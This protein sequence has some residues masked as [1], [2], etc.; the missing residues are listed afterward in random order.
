MRLSSKSAPP[1]ARLNPKGQRRVGGGALVAVL[2]GLYRFY[3]TGGSAALTAV[4]FLFT[5]SL[6]SLALML[7]WF[8]VAKL[9]RRME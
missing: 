2:R 3:M 5:G 6:W 9:F 8:L 7:P 1:R 4:V